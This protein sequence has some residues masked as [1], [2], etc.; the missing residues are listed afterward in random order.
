MRETDGIILATQIIQ[1][2]QTS[3]GRKF[4][5]NIIQVNIDSVKNMEEL[6]AI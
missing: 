5:K 2:V 4:R 3:S 6:L 1:S